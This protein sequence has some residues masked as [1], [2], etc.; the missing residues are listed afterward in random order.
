M[1]AADAS[2]RAGNDESSELVAVRV[3]AER[4]HSVLV[5]ADAFQHAAEQRA[6]QEDE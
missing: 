4:T 2:E 6:Q 3:E 5:D 1:I